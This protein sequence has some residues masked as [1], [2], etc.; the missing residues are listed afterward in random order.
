MTTGPGHE[1][2]EAPQ[3]PARS[4][5][6]RVLGCLMTGIFLIGPALLWLSTRFEPGGGDRPAVLTMGAVFTIISAVAVGALLWQNARAREIHRRLD[7]T[8][9]RATAEV[10]SSKR[11]LI[12]EAC[13]PADELGLLVTGA[14]VTPFEARHTTEDI[15]RY[16][17]GAHIPVDVDPATNLFRL[18]V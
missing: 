10:V 12:G 18:A 1:G 6:G 3:I 17:V 4:T 16:Q 8:G 2:K 14:G 11:I 15:D 5:F 9:I 13:S 7:R